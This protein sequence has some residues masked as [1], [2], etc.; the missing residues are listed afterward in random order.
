MII[1]GVLHFVQWDVFA[2]AGD[3]VAATGGLALRVVLRT[4]IGTAQ[5]IVRLLNLGEGRRVSVFV[6]MMQ[7][8]QGLRPASH[9]PSSASSPSNC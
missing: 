7:K 8:G 9:A 2:D 5:H 1:V 6:R 4:G 3:W